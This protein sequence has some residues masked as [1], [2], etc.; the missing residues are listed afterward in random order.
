MINNTRI[1]F[2]FIGLYTLIIR[3]QKRFTSVWSQTILAPLVTAILFLSIFS[4]V[5]SSRSVGENSIPYVIFMAPGILTMVILQ[6]SFA[7]TSSSILISKVNTSTI[8][9]VFEMDLNFPIS[10][11]RNYNNGDLIIFSRRPH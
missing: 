4:V 8:E 1:Q 11:Y 3:E 10:F 5:L 7:N 6:N 2:N 9:K